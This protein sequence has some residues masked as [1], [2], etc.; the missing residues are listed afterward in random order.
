MVLVAKSKIELEPRGRKLR[1]TL[2]FP[3]HHQYQ[4]REEPSRVLPTSHVTLPPTP[5]PWHH[6]RPR[7][8]ACHRATTP[9]HSLLQ[10]DDRDR[11]RGFFL[12]WHPISAL[13]HHRSLRRGACHQGTR[14]R[15]IPG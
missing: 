9:Q 5:V 10:C 14:P 8:S 1:S 12:W 11:S 13:S 3:I 6:R 7:R 2:S 15:S 4:Y